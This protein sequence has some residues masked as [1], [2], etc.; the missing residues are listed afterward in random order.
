MTPSQDPKCLANL[1][2]EYDQHFSIVFRGYAKRELA[3]DEIFG[4]NT[5][6]IA[7]VTLYFVTCTPF[8]GNFRSTLYISHCLSRPGSLC[9]HLVARFSSFDYH[10][11]SPSFFSAVALSMLLF[12]QTRMDIAFSPT[13]SHRALT[14]VTLEFSWGNFDEARGNEFAE[15]N[16]YSLGY[17]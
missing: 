7:D 10:I 13:A 8:G 3:V 5:L 17:S 2:A 11:V 1:Q 16:R 14:R 12:Y 4:F 15:S 6:L 9:A